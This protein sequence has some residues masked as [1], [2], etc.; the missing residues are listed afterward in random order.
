MPR[1]LPIPQVSLGSATVTIKIK[2]GTVST[3]ASLG[4]RCLHQAPHLTLAWLLEF[5][6]FREALSSSMATSLNQ[7]MSVW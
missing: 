7:S 4:F 1:A 6:P 2:L 3:L 5:C